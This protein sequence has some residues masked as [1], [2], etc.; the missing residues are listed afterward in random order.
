[1]RRTPEP[2][3]V[4]FT[5]G[6]VTLAG[7]LSLPSGA[8]P[9]AEH[10]GVVL[11]GGSGP[12]DRD[13]DTY[14]PPIRQRLLAAGLAVLSYDKRGV[15]GSSGDWRA[16]TLADL[17]GDARAAL[18][19]LRAHPRVRPGAVGLFGHSEGGWVAL[20][21]AAEEGEG[22]AWVVTSGC[23]G[24]TPAIQERYAL[25]RSLRA[26]GIT[27]LRIARV[28]AVYDGLVAAGRNGAGF[29]T[30]SRLVDSAG[31][32]GLASFW[33]DTDAS[34]WEFHKRKQDH[35]PL[36]DTRRLR[37]PHLAL[38]G[39]ADPLVPVAESVRLFGTAA[40][41]PERDPLATLTV[42][43]F[44][45][46]DHRVRVGDGARPAPG[47]LTRLTRWIEERTPNGLTPPGAPG[48]RTSPRG[49]ADPPRSPLG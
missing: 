5:N 47:Y 14:F 16:S 35:D 6:P 45:G 19:L 23:P 26:G 12:S 44:P 3:E 24:T 8:E 33:A 46:A 28:L 9:G 17:A 20:R 32:P 13:N 30:A 48:A 10:A 34:L 11:I 39:G 27:P 7:S 2:Q 18:R 41:L 40:C 42:E 49:H 4:T 36:T 22:L 1:M 43:V 25:A 38:F 37:C 21:A 15:G 31:R 29:V